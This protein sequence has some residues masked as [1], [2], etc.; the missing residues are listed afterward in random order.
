M[1]PTK[2]HYFFLTV[3][4]EIGFCYLISKFPLDL[5]VKYQLNSAGRPLPLPTIVNFRWTEH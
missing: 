5:K 4:A 2:S 1:K 3:D